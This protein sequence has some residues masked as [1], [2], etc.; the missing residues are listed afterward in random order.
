MLAQ[1]PIG[2]L[3]VLFVTGEYATGMIRASLS[4]VPHRLSVL[5]AEAVVVATASFVLCTIGCLAAF[6]L[7]QAGV[8]S[9]GS[10]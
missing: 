4:A 3:G 1:L 9:H 2:V 7:G 10:A 6:L 8:N 5:T